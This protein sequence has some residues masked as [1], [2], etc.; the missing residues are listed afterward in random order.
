MCRL[1]GGEQ[2]DEEAVGAGDAFGEFAEEGEAGVDVDAFAEMRVD[3]A[4]IEIFFAGVMH[5]KERG[6]F[7]VEV[8]PVIEAT[9]LDPV[10]EVGG[11]DFVGRVEQRV[12]G[13]QEFHFSR[14]PRNSPLFPYTT[15]LHLRGGLEPPDSG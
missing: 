6:V 15:L 13:L 14:R 9:F 7:G 11:G 4:A 5:G 1:W 8:A 3:E 12:V 10:L 2:I